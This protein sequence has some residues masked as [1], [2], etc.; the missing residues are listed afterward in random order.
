MIDTDA[1]STVT[2]HDLAVSYAGG[3]PWTLANPTTR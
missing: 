1:A 2:H 3:R